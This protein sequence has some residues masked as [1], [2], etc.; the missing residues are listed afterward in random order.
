MKQ[1]SPGFGDLILFDLKGSKETI[2]SDGIEISLKSPPGIWSPDS[3]FVIYSKKAQLYYLSI[4]QIE[5]K[6]LIAE[7]YRQIGEGHTGNVRWGKGGHLYYVSGS[8]VYRLDS[9]ELFT[10]AIYSGYLQI[11]K[12]C[13]KIPFEFDPNFDSFWISPAGREIL[14][15][16][17]GRNIFLY[18]LS[19]ED[20]LSTG[21]TQSLPYL[22]LP[23]N[24]WIK[25]VL[26]AKS[27]TI[28]IISEGIEKG[29][30]R[31]AVFR[32]PS[33]EGTTIPAFQQIEVEGSQVQDLVLSPDEETIVVIQE[34][35]VLLKNYERWED[36]LEHPHLKPLHVLWASEEELII[37][38]TYFTELW[39]I[40]TDETSVITIS[41]P[42]L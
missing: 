9:R 1:K 20:F 29:K 2:I 23:R 13:G 30:I 3:R 12:I 8:L 21:N 41:Q 35:R 15:N 7:T 5:E 33:L 18:I 10:R 24:T 28:T 42:G 27:C 14:L 38:G 39:N 31:T 4:S 11:G 19:N 36:E 37:A 6:R 32:L 16:K 22:Y 40:S 17:G 26:W 34:D 25:N